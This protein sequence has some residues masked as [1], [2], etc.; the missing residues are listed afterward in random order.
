LEIQRTFAGRTAL[1]LGYAFAPVVVALP[2]AWLLTNPY[3]MLRTRQ[4]FM[5]NLEMAWSLILIVA[6]LTLVLR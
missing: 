5:L 3:T 6:A 1:S 2:I 4:A